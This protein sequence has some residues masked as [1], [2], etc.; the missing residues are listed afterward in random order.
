MK[1]WG[2]LILLVLALLLAA[3][4]GTAPPT[5]TITVPAPD[6]DLPDMPVSTILAPADGTEV[7]VGFEVQVQSNSTDTV[8][9]VRVDLLVNGA[10][11]K[12][13]PTPGSTPQISFSVS[14]SFVP[15]QPGPYNVSVVA[16][17]EDGTAGLP[18]VVNLNAVEGNGAG[19]QQ[20]GATST[21]TVVV[22]GPTPTQSD[23][24]EGAPQVTATSTPTQDVGVTATPSFTPTE[25]VQLTATFTP[26]Y[27]PTTPPAVQV[28]PEDARFNS[29]LTIP[30]DNTASVLDFVSYPSG[31]TEDRVRWEVTGM[32][33]NASLSGGRARL[34]IAASC[35]GNGT[36]FISFFTGGQSFGCGQTLFDQ[37]ITY[38][39]RTG[40]VVITAIGGD[41][42]YV[43]W[44]L[45]G[46]A[47]RTN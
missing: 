24:S 3:C 27:T 20:Q 42:T 4:G 8:G 7:P 22:D 30:L 17:R 6:Q 14:Q 39:S 40:S 32:N 26:S 21:A 23:A 29:P 10:V 46:T 31:D 12:S 45:T 34:V 35:F 38:D 43:Q 33:Q 5:I 41:E 44:V 15:D 1:R 11:V 47:T 25:G 18:A 28:A 13:E 37:E 36:E 9:V 16:Y 2:S 19:D